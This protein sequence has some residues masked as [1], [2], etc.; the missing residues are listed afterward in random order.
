VTVT[1]LRSADRPAAAWKNGGG[2]TREVAS[3]PEDAGLD[4]FDWRISLAEVASGG[5]FS[6]FPG[7]DRVITVV[8]GGGMELTVDG[9]RHSVAE[10][11]RPFAFPGDAD[12]RCRLLD[13]AITDLNV[14]TRRGR[15][16][17]GVEIVRASRP[18]PSATGRTMVLLVLEG[19]VR[20]GRTLLGRHDAVLD[21]GTGD[22]DGA[23]VV[24]EDGAS[25]AALI[26][27]DDISGL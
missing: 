12:T 5:P 23:S 18:L 25:V 15:V 14:M 9:V 11:H 26:T 20:L 22:A 19:Q 16:T 13:G 27:L 17:A 7:V 1:V 2:I 3:W 10:R 4:D 8:D 24:C 21:R 6:A